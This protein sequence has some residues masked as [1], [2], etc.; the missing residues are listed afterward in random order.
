VDPSLVIDPASGQHLINLK[1]QIQPE[2]EHVDVLI[3]ETKRLLEYVKELDPAA[4]S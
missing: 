2:K 4:I 3:A 1:I